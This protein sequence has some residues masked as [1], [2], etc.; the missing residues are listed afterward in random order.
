MGWI[1]RIIGRVVALVV[2][3]AVAVA[4][5]Y[6]AGA[7]LG[8]VSFQGAPGGAPADGVQVFV[9]SNGFH[10][11]IVV[12]MQA[13]GVDWALELQAEHFTGANPVAASHAGFGWG[14][15]GFYLTT[16]TLMDIDAGTAFEALFDSSG[17]LM[18]VTLWGGTPVPGPTV[19]PLRLT[20]AQY[21][22]LTANLRASFQRDAAGA[23]RPIPGAGYRYYDAFY[24]G[25]GTYSLFETCNEWTAAQ[26]RRIGVAV[27][28]WAPFPFG[29]MWHL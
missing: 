27:G 25:V 24:E 22:Q 28:W 26:L 23:V 20:S 14:D 4:L 21:T 15:R 29:V 5:L 8:T 6:G 7:L 18:H 17:S 10:T 11:D 19:R 1:L 16:P 13:Q 9:V 2:G 3:L 12:P